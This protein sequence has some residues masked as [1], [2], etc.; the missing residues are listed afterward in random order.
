MRRI[1]L[2]LVGAALAWTGPGWAQAPTVQPESRNEKLDKKLEAQ[3]APVIKAWEAGWNQHDA[4]ALSSLFT[5]DAVMIN[6][7]GDVA[8]GPANIE[9]LLK[10]AHTG[11][12]KDSQVTTRVV[13]L[14]QIVPGVLMVDQE[15]TITGALDPQGR[16]L[17]RIQSHLASVLKKEGGKW[18]VLH[19]RAYRFQPPPAQAVG[20]SGE[21]PE[22]TGEPMQTPAPVQE[23][24]PADSPS[25]P[26]E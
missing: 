18:K 13:D 2:G 22:S 25:P 16:P 7:G 20:G 12:M 9:Q 3:L 15:M 11:W 14:D 21:S 23:G 26:E 6:P 19:A 4:K 10:E 8:R 5:Q 17:P 24:N 1:A